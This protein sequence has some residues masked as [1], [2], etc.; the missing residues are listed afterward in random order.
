MSAAYRVA[1]RSDFDA[2]WD[3]NEAE[4]PD[5]PMWPV[6]RQRFRERIDKGLAITFCVVI[7]GDPV[8][9]GTLEL[10]TGK[11]KRLCDGR[12]NA[13]LAAL[14][15]RKEFEGMGHIFRLV[16]MMEDHAR[17]LGFRRVTIGVEETEARNREIYA[18][19]GYVNLVME[20]NQ[21]GERVLYYGKKL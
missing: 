2:L 15:I 10:N 9:E 13:Y 19:W 1:T 7:D 11:D 3:R 4:N 12:T 21:D 16:S 20:E 6:W 14:R 5:E 8:G 18:H 17:K